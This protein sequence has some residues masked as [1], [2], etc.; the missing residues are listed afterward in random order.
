MVSV[1]TD[2]TQPSSQQPSS[3]VSGSETS[4]AAQR[5][6]TVIGAH[7][8]A[9]RMRWQLPLGSTTDLRPQRARN[10]TSPSTSCGGIWNSTNSAGC[11]TVAPAVHSP[12]GTR[13]SN[14]QP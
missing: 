8:A 3:I 1:P 4:G 13:Y 11:G 5:T 6:V 12:P 2:S 10:D 7:Q 9:Q 14:C